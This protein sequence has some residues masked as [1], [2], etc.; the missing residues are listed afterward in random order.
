MKG[1]V[2]L[3]I[4]KAPPYHILLF[5]P[6]RRTWCGLQFAFEP[7]LKLLKEEPYDDQTLAVVCPGCRTAIV[8]AVQ[9]VTP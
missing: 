6:F 9:E 3:R 1:T 2:Q 8:D 7:P 5:G 4:L